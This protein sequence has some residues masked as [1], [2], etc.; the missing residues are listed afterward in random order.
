MR[1]SDGGVVGVWGIGSGE[2]DFESCDV[3]GTRSDHTSEVVFSISGIVKVVEEDGREGIDNG[4]DTLISG[5]TLDRGESFLRIF[6]RGGDVFWNGGQK[7]WVRRD[8]EEKKRVGR[9]AED[10]K[11]TLI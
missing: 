9:D 1:I 3:G 2:G 6:E 11:K 5:L 10:R 7:R 8:V 4:V